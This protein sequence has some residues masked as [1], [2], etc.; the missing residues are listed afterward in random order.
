M[1]Q[2]FDTNGLERWMTDSKISDC[3]YAEPKEWMWNVSTETKGKTL[4]YRISE[5][6]Q[7]FGSIT[8]SFPENQFLVQIYECVFP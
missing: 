6:V 7:A 4:S 2:S 8:M 1:L 3:L 5:S